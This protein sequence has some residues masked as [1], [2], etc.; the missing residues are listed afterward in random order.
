M[1]FLDFLNSPAFGSI[2]K[3]V[4]EPFGE[5]FQPGSNPLNMNWGQFISLLSGLDQET[6]PLGN[7]VQQF[8]PKQ[9]GYRGPQL[10][11]FNPILQQKISDASDI[12]TVGQLAS[13]FFGGSPIG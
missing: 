11:M 5:V 9:Q 8:T 10:Q 4:Q 13:L 12:A 7:L 1:A 2:G 6:A 3:V